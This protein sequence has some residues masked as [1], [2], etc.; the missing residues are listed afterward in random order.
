M[1]TSKEFKDIC[2][3]WLQDTSSVNRNDIAKLID[4]VEEY[5]KLGTVEEIHQAL[6][7][8]K[9][10]IELVRKLQSANDNLRHK[11]CGI[12]LILEE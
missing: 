7:S 5:V 4:S 3:R 6:D 2:N 8:F 12:E 11:L 10:H 9:E 1:L